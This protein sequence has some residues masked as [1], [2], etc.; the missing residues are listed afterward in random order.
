MAV[1]IVV[2]EFGFS[3]SGWVLLCLVGCD[4]GGLEPPSL[5]AALFT[6]CRDSI[7]GKCT[8]FP[9]LGGKFKKTGPRCGGGEAV[10]APSVL[11]P[12]GRRVPSLPGP[13]A[14]Q[15]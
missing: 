11:G 14:P 4:L 12:C 13:A 9:A 15:A 6:D 2:L 1:R 10:G 7:W 5:V 8:G 3:D